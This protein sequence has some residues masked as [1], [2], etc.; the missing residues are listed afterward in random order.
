MPTLEP[1]VVQ[2]V[3]ALDCGPK[4]ANVTVPVAVAGEVPDRTELIEVDATAVP[5]VPVD[6]PES[7]RAGVAFVMVSV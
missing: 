6:G 7:V 5:A 3:G 4:T 2:L 1:P